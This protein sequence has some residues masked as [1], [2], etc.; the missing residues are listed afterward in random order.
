ML[1]LSDAGDRDGHA[2]TRVH[3][4]RLD[5]QRHRAQRDSLHLLDAGEHDG[6]TANDDAGPVAVAHPGDHEGLV[7][8]ARD[9]PDVEAH[10]AREAADAEKFPTTDRPTQVVK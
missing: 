8:A 6:A 1:Y 3:S 2:L 7:G 5:D 4:R 9:N 10:F